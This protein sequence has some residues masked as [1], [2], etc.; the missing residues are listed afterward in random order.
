MLALERNQ[1]RP[2]EDIRPTTLCFV[3]Q[4]NCTCIVFQHGCRRYE[5]HLEVPNQRPSIERLR[6]VEI[7]Y[8]QLSALL[9]SLE[10]PG[11]SVMYAMSVLIQ[12]PCRA[13]K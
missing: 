6:Q 9:H 8:F 4:L 7:I 13:A 2:F 12:T 11:R 3:S 10:H 1:L 5:A